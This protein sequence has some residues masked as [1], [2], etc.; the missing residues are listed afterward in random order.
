VRHPDTRG[1]QRALGLSE[2]LKTNVVKN[3]TPQVKKK[4]PSQTEAFQ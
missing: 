2:N 1:S 3:F 4:T